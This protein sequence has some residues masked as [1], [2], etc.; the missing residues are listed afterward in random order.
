MKVIKK[1]NGQ[2]GWS[3][4]FTCTGAGNNGGGCRAVLQVE[5]ADLFRTSSTDVSQCTETF[6]TFRCP[7]CRVQ[8]DVTVPQNIACQLPLK[9]YG[10]IEQ[11]DLEARRGF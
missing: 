1:G 9:T 6:T 10:Q 5:Q 3:A 2:R 11:E 7:E 4:Q 8:T